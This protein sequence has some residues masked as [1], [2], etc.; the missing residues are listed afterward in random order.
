M[1]RREQRRYWIVHNNRQIRIIKT[2]KSRFYYAL[3]A[4]AQSFLEA[5]RQGQAQQFINSFLISPRI[6]ATLQQLVRVVGS[7][8]A[9][10]NYNG[11]RTEKSLSDWFQQI[12]NYLGQNFY[13]KGV[14]KIVQT[15]RQIFTDILNKGVTEGWG[16]K[17]MAKYIKDEVSGINRSRAEMIARTEVG[18]AIHAGQ[19]VGADASPFQ[20]QN[21]WISAI[22]ARTRRNPKLKHNGADHVRLNG[23]VVDF[24][25]PF[26]DPSNNV[27]LMHPHDPEA[28]AVEVIRCRCT[29][30]TTNKRDSEG[31]L[32]RKQPSNR[33]AVILPN[34]RV[35]RTMITI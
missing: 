12:M 15:S 14:F 33:V 25:Q 22:D 17:E 10:L 13:D 1:N 11:L 19:Y 2:Y 4:D 21:T 32:I 7:R 27:R 8:Y 35:D 5:Y 31:R 29:Y 3:Q 9:R 16:Y 26:I 6:T 20:K 28:P 24:G 23:Q 18:R 30:A 34:Q